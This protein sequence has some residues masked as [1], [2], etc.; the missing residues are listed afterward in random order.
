MVFD[1]IYDYILE[2]KNYDKNVIRFSSSDA[3]AKLS[4]T[5]FNQKF[6]QVPATIYLDAITLIYLYLYEVTTIHFMSKLT[7]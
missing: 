1:E 5:H 3:E 7:F 4:I 6:F 2:I